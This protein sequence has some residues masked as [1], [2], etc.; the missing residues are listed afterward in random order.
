MFSCGRAVALL[1]KA[2]KKGILRNKLVFFFIGRKCVKLKMQLKEA[3]DALSRETE[4]REG[5]NETNGACNAW[6][7]RPSHQVRSFRQ[8]ADREKE[9]AQIYLQHAHDL[10]KAC[11]SFERA[12]A[13]T[14]DAGFKEAAD[15]HAK[16][17]EYLAAI[18]RYEQVADRPLTSAL[19]KAS[20]CALA[21]GDLIT[22]KRNIQNYNSKDNTFSSTRDQEAFT[23]AVGEFDQT[24]TSINEEPNLL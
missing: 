14:A 1:Q 15:L 7:H 17:E 20:L 5:C 6:C 16:L 22:A 23:G 3:G 24:K 12:G 18:T 8:T 2:D 9:I 4:C 19:T 10:H 11:E 13:R 21:M